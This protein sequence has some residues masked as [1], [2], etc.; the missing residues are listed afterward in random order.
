MKKYLRKVTIIYLAIV[1][2]LMSN[3]SIYA[4]TRT[5]SEDIA[6]KQ[7]NNDDLVGI[8]V[9]PR[10]QLISS[11]TLE[12]SDEGY[13][14]IGIYS[15]VLCHVEV[16]KIKMA[17]IL[18][19]YEDGSWTQVNRKDVEWLKEDYPNDDLSMAIVAYKLRGLSAGSYRL[20]ANYSVFE[21][22]GSLQEFKTVTTGAMDIR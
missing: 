10:G 4:Q 14:A 12:L 13:R 15:E 7:Y 22:D 3:L 9:S 2:M 19:K 16:R 20:K 5:L 11:A 18:Q 17:V 1:M 6:A 8:Q 21:L